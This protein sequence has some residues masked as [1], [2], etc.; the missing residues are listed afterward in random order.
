MKERIL[1]TKSRV[2]G[3]AVFVVALAVYVMTLAPG[4]LWGGGDFATFQTRLYTFDL[5]IDIWGHPLWVIL[6]H[7]FVWLPLRDVAYR[8]NVAA[9]FFAAFALVFVFHSAYSL[10]R[11]AWASLLA[12]GALLV[13]HLFWLLAVT[14]K[15]YSLSTLMLALCIY[16]LLRWRSD[17]RDLFLYLSAFLFALGLMNHLVLAT[18]ALGIAPFVL[19]V[20]R[21]RARTLLSRELLIASLFFVLGLIPYVVLASDVMQASN[22]S[23]TFRGFLG[24][25]WAALTAPVSMAIGLGLGLVLL[26][27][28]F[29]I[30]ILAGGLGLRALLQADRAVA[31]LLGGI[32]LGNVLLLLL[33]VPSQFS[34]DYVWN[35]QYYFPLYISIALMIAVGF[36]K[37]EPRLQ[38]SGQSAAAILSTILLPIVIYWAAPIIARPLAANMP[39]FR[40]IGNRDNLTYVL[41]PWKQ[42]ETGARVFGENI[43]DS[44]P[45][46]SVLF[47]DYSIWAIVNYLQVVEGQRLDI[48]LV[49][50]SPANSG[51][52]LPAILAHSDRPLFVADIG[53]Y[54]DMAAIQQYFSVQPAGAVYRLVPK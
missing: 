29:P 5:R 22:I 33:L 53:R 2:F 54:Y 44:L 49:E 52:Q 9:A 1:H 39:G 31:M 8:A 12:T 34:A 24:S 10:T 18:A 26:I 30:T 46:N 4:L 3:I 25:A 37:L 50:L 35:L 36:A 13:S 16:L 42:S 40:Q 27:Y 23:D 21:D 47:A 17:R 41:S 43:L 38:T 20:M 15:V 14:A 11:S 7:P 28:Q 32:A 48:D 6:A 45:R 19:L 51:Q